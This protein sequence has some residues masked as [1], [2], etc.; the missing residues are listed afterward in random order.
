VT[1]TFVHGQE[2][3]VYPNT[4]V[5]NAPD[6]LPGTV[7]EVFLVAGTRAE[8]IK[9]APVLAVLADYGR[10]RPVL[11]SSGQQPQLVAQALDAFGRSPDIQLPVRQESGTQAELCGEIMARLDPVLVARRPSAVLVQG[12]S[13]TALA[14]ALAAFWRRIPVVHLG[15]GLRSYDLTAPF[16]EEGNR[17]L[18]GQLASLHLPPTPSAAA[19]LAAEGIAGPNVLTVGNTAVDAVLDAAD[20]R[21]P[22]SHPRLQAIDAAARQGR[23]RL[24]LVTVQRPENRGAALDRILGAVCDLLDQHPDLEVVL[25]TGPCPAGRDRV[26]RAL[27][28]Q[29]RVLVTGPLPYGDVARLLSAASLV[30][31]D[32]GGLL[33]EAPTFG[34]PVLVLREVTERPEALAAGCARLVGTDR[35]AVTAEASLLLSDE[36]ARL[37]LT[38]AG[39]P[40]GDGLAAH[41]TEEALA[42]LLGLRSARPTPFGDVPVRAVA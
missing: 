8:A 23:R 31:S 15:A 13:T 9:T 29:R 33:E 2:L 14:A 22:Y 36:A 11:V 34:V 7:P 24:V 39:N 28:G 6:R 19:N 27:A 37:D 32:S 41:R 18:V 3:P 42:W 20:R 1:S 16:P 17:K 25:P 26:Y 40:F 4:L 12:D 21:R 10:M 35:G 30:L 38:V 5:P